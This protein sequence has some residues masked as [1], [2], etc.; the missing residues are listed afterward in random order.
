MSDAASI[1]SNG[2]I[3]KSFSVQILLNCGVGNCDKGGD[4]FE[5]LAF[6]HKYGVTE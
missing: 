3:S 1:R 2:Q 4:P 5:A 6:I